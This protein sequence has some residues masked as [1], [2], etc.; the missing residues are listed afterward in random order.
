[1]LFVLLCFV[2]TSRFT[3]QLHQLLPSA[4]GTQN[5]GSISDEALA[6]QGV[7][8][9]GTDE[10]VVVPVAVLERDEAGSADSSDRLGAGGASL[11]KQLTEALG[12]V[13]LLIARCE[14]LAG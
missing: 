7:S 10:A 3:A 14:S 6:D 12:T 5:V 4:F 1:M 8:A 13:W 11:G 2:R 9:H